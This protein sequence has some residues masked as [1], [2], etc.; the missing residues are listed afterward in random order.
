M[1]R[2]AGVFCAFWT[3][4]GVDGEVLWDAFDLNLDFVLRSGVH[5][6]MALGST[7]E[8]PHF[9]SATRKLILERIAQACSS[10]G[11]R[12]IIANVSHVSCRTACGLARH[13]K[14]CGAT[15]ASVLPPWFYPS[16]QRDLAEFFIRVGKESGLPLALYNY[17]E[18]TGKKIELETIR[19]VAES[20]PVALVKQSGAD[21][22]YHQPLL[23]LGREIGFSVLTGADT[24]LPEALHLGCTGTVSGLAN[25][26]PDVLCTIFERFQRNE[27][28]S[29]PAKFMSQIAELMRPLDF[30]LNVKAAMSARDIETG[31][32]KN[33]ITRETEL[34]Y[35]GV[36]ATLRQLCSEYL[37]EKRMVTR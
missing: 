7:A 2:L 9:E 33:P 24:R 10:R 32:L 34:I 35:R 29:G 37:G 11:G 22:G 25:V 13:A 16:L 18:V 15:V 4:T 26:A 30:P 28:T 21:F 31:E 20:V 14:D 1:E 8:F 3:P 17:P 36:L 12:P 23:Q 5:G 27:D 19:Q 6:I